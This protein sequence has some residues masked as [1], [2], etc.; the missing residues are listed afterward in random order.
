M[1]SCLLNWLRRFGSDALPQ[2]REFSCMEAVCRC[3]RLSCALIAM[4]WEHCTSYAEPVLLVSSRMQH[5][6]QHVA[7]G[8]F[9]CAD[10]LRQH[11]D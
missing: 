1:H 8:S 5:V 3:R 6:M 2:C 9:V 4:S 7:Q 10:Y 11:F